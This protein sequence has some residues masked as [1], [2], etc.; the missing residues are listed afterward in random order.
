MSMATLKNNG[1]TT[2]LQILGSLASDPILQEKTVT[3]S[4]AEQRVTP[5][6]G[7][8]GLSAVNVKG[9]LLQTKSVTATKED[10]YVQPDNGYSGLAIVEVKGYEV[11]KISEIA[12][13][14]DTDSFTITFEDGTSV[15]G[16]VIFD[17]AGNPV[18]LID[19]AGNTVEFSDGQ[20]SSVTDSDGH[21]VSIQWG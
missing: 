1:K 14:E 7:Y 20:P 8:D 18:T 19:N 9:V 12:I 6:S 21:T 4:D 15:S 2:K 5:D 16:T 11:N 10:Q 13:L 3:P 17:D